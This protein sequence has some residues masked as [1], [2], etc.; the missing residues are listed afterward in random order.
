LFSRLNIKSE[1]LS[2]TFN[3]PHPLPLPAGERG[4]VRGEISNIFS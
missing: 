3:P 2:L 1:N 4:R